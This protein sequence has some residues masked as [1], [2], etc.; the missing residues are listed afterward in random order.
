MEE[1]TIYKYT[2]EEFKDKVNDKIGNVRLFKK[3]LRKQGF[4]GN[5]QQFSKEHIKIFEDVRNYKRQYNTTW[6]VAFSEGLKIILGQNA[7]QFLSSNYISEPFHN[8]IEDIIVE[9]LKT[10]QRIESKL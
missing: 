10:L 7:I 5:R 6:E 4:I 8:N 1:E 9:I 2:D 3:H